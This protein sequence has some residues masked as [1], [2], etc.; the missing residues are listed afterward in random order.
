MRERIAENMMQVRPQ[1]EKS[2]TIAHEQ[3]PPG[4]VGGVPI[5][6]SITGDQP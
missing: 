6:Q 4:A 5:K 2:A 3:P 1:Q